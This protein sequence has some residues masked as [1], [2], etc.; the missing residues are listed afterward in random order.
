MQ[1]REIRRLLEEEIPRSVLGEDLASTPK[2][3]LIEPGLISE[4]CH[5]LHTHEKTYLDS[6]SCLTGVDNGAEVHSMEVIYN[7]YSIP[8]D[9]HL[10]LKVS[11][12]RADLILDSVSSIWKT[13]DWHEREIYDLLGIQ[14]KGHPDLRRILL[15]DDWDG[16]PLRKDYVE[17][18][19]YH[20]VKVKY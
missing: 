14:F 20:D 16:H 6:L 2:A 3:L 5:F 17:Q 19:E 4:V 10:M 8:Y 18:E 15:P 12:D 1:F 11:L 13:A 7:L 9:V